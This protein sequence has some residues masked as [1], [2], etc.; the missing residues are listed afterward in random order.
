MEHPEV[1]ENNLSIMEN[2]KKGEITISWSNS[3]KKPEISTLYF[4]WDAIIFSIVGFKI[5]D[6]SSSQEFMFDLR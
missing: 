5:I 4:P 6:T 2:N 1:T 3:G